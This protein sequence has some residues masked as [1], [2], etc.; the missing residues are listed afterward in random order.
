MLG[1]LC[2]IARSSGGAGRDGRVEKR[3]PGFCDA[4]DRSYLVSLDF[5]TVVDPSQERASASLACISNWCRLVLDTPKPLIP[6]LTH[7]DPI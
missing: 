3:R 4:D 2:S 7:G 6:P 1:C 5:V